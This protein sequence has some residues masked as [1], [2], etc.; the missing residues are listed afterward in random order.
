MMKQSYEA[1]KQQSVMTMT[2]A[3]MLTMLYDGVLK[4]I[5]IV[6]KAFEQEPKDI[7]EINRGLQKAHRILLY[8]KTSLDTN[9]PIANNLMSL[10]DY[11][12]WIITQ[13]NM[14]KDPSGLDEAADMISQL[15]ETYIQADRSVRKMHA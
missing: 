6:Q 10:Y 12:D 11:I 15:K 8:L 1:Y 3:E 2:P 7:A 13:A 4:E 9:Y 14:K 5:Y